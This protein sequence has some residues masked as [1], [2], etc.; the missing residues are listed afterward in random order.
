LVCPRCS[1][2]RG[3]EGQVTILPI[4]AD[5]EI[6]WPTSKDLA[7]PCAM[8]ICKKKEKTN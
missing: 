4:D 7:L 5:T 1:R 3:D 8:R 2:A 6:H